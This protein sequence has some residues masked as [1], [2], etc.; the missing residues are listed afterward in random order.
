MNKEVNSLAYSMILDDM[1]QNFSFEMGYD[2]DNNETPFGMY[3]KAVNQ[4]AHN[5]NGQ[6][7]QLTRIMIELDSADDQ[8]KQNLYNF[9]NLV[10]MDQSIPYYIRTFIAE[11]G[12]NRTSWD[13]KSQEGVRAVKKAYQT[14]L[15]QSYMWGYV[16]NPTI[17]EF[18][19]QMSEGGKPA[20]KVKPPVQPTPVLK[21]LSQPQN[22][23]PE[24]PPS[25]PPRPP[26][27]PKRPPFPPQR[28]P[29]PPQRPPSPPQRPPSPPQRPPSPPVEPEE[30]SRNPLPEPRYEDPTPFKMNNNPSQFPRKPSKTIKEMHQD[31]S[32]GPDYKGNRFASKGKKK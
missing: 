5:K 21:N 19:T 12:Q 9:M 17:I 29:S 13:L 8:S 6:I 23:V 11:F 28:P 2:M 14:S 22:P 31:E 24:E 10:E 16:E 4:K 26:S 15:D 27:P 32:A 25:P 30:P 7:T 18:W 20:S 1:L 3:W